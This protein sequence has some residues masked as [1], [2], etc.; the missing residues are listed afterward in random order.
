MNILDNESDI[1]VLRVVV[2]EGHSEDLLEHLVLDTVWAYETLVD[3]LEEQRKRGK[4]KGDGKGSDAKEEAKGEKEKKRGRQEEEKDEQKKEVRL[5]KRH[6]RH[7][8]C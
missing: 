2:R 4:G 3:K 8:P 7:G 5:E 1:Y 6:V